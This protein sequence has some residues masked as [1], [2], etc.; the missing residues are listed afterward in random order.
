MALPTAEI[1][2]QF[3]ILQRLIASHSLAYLDNA[4]TTQK[5][6]CV[7]DA[8]EL[9]YRTHN[10][11]AH[12]GMHVL[13]EEATNAYEN[14]RKKVQHL[15]GAKHAEEIVFTKSCTEAINLVTKSW[16]RTNLRRDDRVILTTLEHHSNIIPWMQLREE[17]GIRLSWIDLD[18]NGDLRYEQF[19]EELQR[20]NV[21]LVATTGQ[22]NV[23]GVQPKLPRIIASAHAVGTLV[24]VDAAQL[25][26]H[27]PIDVQKLDCDFLAFSG[28][29]LY[30]PTGIGVFYAKRE[31]LEKMPPML[32]GGGMVQTVSEDSYTPLDPPA[33]F[34]AGTPPVAEAIGLATAID[35]LSQFSWPDIIAHEQQL[36][37][38]AEE[39]LSPIPGL[40]ILPSS[41][42]NTYNLTPNTSGCL[43]FTIDG[44]HPHDLTEI[45]G[46]ESICL[47]AGHHCTQPLHRHL[48]I[49]TSTRLSVA[50]Y[51]TL[52]EI[53]RL[54]AA[55]ERARRILTGKTA[56]CQLQTTY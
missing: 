53:D 31:L 42:S 25:V 21:R 37:R 11:N 32:G 12:R 56:N 1:R 29:K 26:A 15:L 45:L 28:H 7:L 40:T 55:I 20:G 41:Q 54:P 9:Y 34:E 39:I 48:G 16:G 24:L 3:P 17:V 10:A 14:A 5:P 46:R 6:D 47:R 49:S 52:E 44:L 43:S 50:L 27:H 30:G 33:R 38:R 51:N 18:D 36:L 2:H 13:A 19:A 23:L 35:W 4:A 8:M 22:S